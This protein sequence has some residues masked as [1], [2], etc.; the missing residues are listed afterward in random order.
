MWG[1]SCSN[2]KSLCLKLEFFPLDDST[3]SLSF[4]DF[5]TPDVDSPSLPDSRRHPSSIPLTLVSRI[6]SEPPCPRRVL[7]TWS[8]SPPQPLFL[9]SGPLRRISYFFLPH[10]SVGGYEGVVNECALP[11]RPHASPLRARS[12]PPSV[13]HSTPC[14][15]PFRFHQRRSP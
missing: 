9:I 10:P 13:A 15:S 2:V 5:A 7:E 11:H 8:Q 4:T 3:A 14:S 12:P 1:F 6:F